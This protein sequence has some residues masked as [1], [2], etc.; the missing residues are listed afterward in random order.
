[1]MSEPLLYVCK[2]TGPQKREKS[3]KDPVTFSPVLFHL[4]GFGDE[5]L[6]DAVA[7]PRLGGKRASFIDGD[8]LYAAV[9]I[10]LYAQIAR[11]RISLR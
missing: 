7:N 8:P 2:I 10:R 6:I 9:L 11:S 4:R 1:M 5:F 3:E